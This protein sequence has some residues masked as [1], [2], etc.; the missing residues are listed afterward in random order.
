[1]KKRKKRNN[2]NSSIR[3]LKSPKKKKKKKGG[4]RNVRWSVT[5]HLTSFI[6]DSS[7]SVVGWAAGN[8]NTRAGHRRRRQAGCFVVF[9]RRG[10]TGCP[11]HDTCSQTWKFFRGDSARL[12]SLL[13][14]NQARPN[15]L[16]DI[17]PTL[18]R[19]SNARSTVFLAYFSGTRPKYVGIKTKN[20]TM[21]CRHSSHH[22]L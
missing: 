1:M 2:Q 10:E 13:I 14:S 22:V 18:S 16:A 3:S 7:Q 19:H 5:Q 21:T 4:R 20:R 9:S 12:S 11:V 15:N 8:L 17:S 6:V